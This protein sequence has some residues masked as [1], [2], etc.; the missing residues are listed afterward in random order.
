MNSTDL[1][2]RLS[3]ALDTFLHLL[4]TGWNQV[5]FL[6]EQTQRSPGDVLADWA[7]ANW[8]F[9]VEAAVSVN[10]R[11]FLE[12]YGDGAD[13][14]AIGSRVWMPGAAS[15]HVVNCAPRQGD[16]S[17]DMLSGNT[18]RFPE[19]GFPVDRFAA[20]RADGWFE[21][22]PPFEHVLVTALG[23]EA[24]FPLSDLQFLLQVAEGAS[25]LPQP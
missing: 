23:Q 24:L 14:N 13:C 5:E 18:I 19:R 15:T 12:P 21:E 16:E 7:Q 2:I 1:D 8:E 22:T 3:L 25:P 6:A 4:R 17:I 9:V 20:L 10:G 11:I